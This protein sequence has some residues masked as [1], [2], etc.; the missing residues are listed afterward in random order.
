MTA[1]NNF[2]RMSLTKTGLWYNSGHD[3]KIV[4][5]EKERNHVQ[6]SPEIR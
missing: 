5:S 1:P 4:I 3:D 6:N 2:D